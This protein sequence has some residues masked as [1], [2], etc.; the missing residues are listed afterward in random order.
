MSLF[1][2]ERLLPEI[3]CCQD[4]LRMSLAFSHTLMKESAPCL[5]S[6]Q[7]NFVSDQA[8]L[9]WPLLCITMVSL[10]CIRKMGDFAI[11]F[12]FSLFF[13][14]FVL[15]SKPL[16]FEINFS[17][18]NAMGAPYV[19]INSNINF[20][21]IRICCRKLEGLIE[22]RLTQ[23]LRNVNQLHRNIFSVQSTLVLG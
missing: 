22:I 5:T 11:F 15:T 17:E 2:R 4:T 21:H 13:P 18:A 16:D 6:V 19:Q 3:L 23:R 14:C 1:N 7:T 12:I 8:E 20:I 9:Q 10:L